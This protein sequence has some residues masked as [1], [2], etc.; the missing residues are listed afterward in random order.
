M[1]KILYLIYLI[2]CIFLDYKEFY[3]IIKDFKYNIARQLILYDKYN[4]SLKNLKIKNICYNSI[5]YLETAKCLHS[6]G[7]ECITNAI[8]WASK[9]CNLE[10]VKYLKSI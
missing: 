10:T 2:Y 9:S 4:N 1:I 8:N 3:N 5:E 7:S 6:I